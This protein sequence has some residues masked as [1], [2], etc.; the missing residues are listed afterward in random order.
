M[1]KQLSK[2]E[3][4]REGFIREVN[5][6]VATEN[7]KRFCRKY[8]KVL[9]ILAVLAVAGVSGYEYYKA[10]KRQRIQNE[11]TQYDYAAGLVESNKEEALS[12]FSKLEQAG[13]TDYAVL[14]SFAIASI[15]YADG[16]KE[17]ADRIMDRV[18]E[19]K[20]IPEAF[21]N[22]A[23]VSQ[24]LHGQDTEFTEKTLMKIAQIENEVSSYKPVLTETKALLAYRN[25]DKAKTISFYQEVLNDNN[26]SEEMKARAREV[27]AYLNE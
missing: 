19:N 12:E 4:D 9:V 6:E 18:A 5:E 16:K 27:I 26:A 15:Y 14:S 22:L 10:M 20:K 8:G 2:E 3:M 7:F 17:A 1:D 25:K 23:K 24:T 11:S 21:R 13:K